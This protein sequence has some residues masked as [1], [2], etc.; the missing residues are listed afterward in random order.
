MDLG[1]KEGTS[2]VGGD[3]V[4]T[5]DSFAALRDRLRRLFRVCRG[6]RTAR[7][8][9]PEGTHIVMNLV[10]DIFPGRRAK[11]MQDTT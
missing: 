6:M 3:C 1:E 10:C 9:F 7:L 8:A 5:L 4:C 11:F 2:K